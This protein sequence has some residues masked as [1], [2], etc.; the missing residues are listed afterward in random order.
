MA[1]IAHLGL[2]RF[3]QIGLDFRGVRRVAI[4]TSDIILEMLRAQKIAVLFSE[5]MACKTTLARFFA[6]ELLEVDDLAY[7]AGFG[8]L[9]SRTVAGLTAL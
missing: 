3:Q 8:M 6:R 4:N 5:L 1:A 9:F 7:I 2:G